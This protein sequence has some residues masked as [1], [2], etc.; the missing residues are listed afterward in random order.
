MTA[1]PQRSSLIDELLKRS[2]LQ[3]V[4]LPTYGPPVIVPTPDVLPVPAEPETQQLEL[5]LGLETL[6]LPSQVRTDLEQTRLHQENRQLKQRYRQALDEITQLELNLS[7][8]AGTHEIETTPIS[9]TTSPEVSSE[10]IPILGWSDWHV[11][12]RIDARTVNGLN[13]YTPEIAEVRA[14]QLAVNSLRL[15]QKERLDRQVKRMVL[16]LGGDFISGYIHPE[17]EESN[18][19]SPTQEIQLA[20]RLICQGIDL[21]LAQGDLEE[22]I[23]PCSIGNHGRT[24]DK[25]RA[26]T[27]AYNSFEWL[28]YCNLSRHYRQEPRVKFQ[29]ADGYCNYLRIF[30]RVLRFAHGDGGFKYQ[31]GVGGIH[32]G[33]NKWIMRANEA[34]KADM[35]V[36]GHFHSLKFDHNF[37]VNGS[38]IGPSAYSLRMGF[39]PERP[40][41]MFRLLDAQYGFTTCAPVLTE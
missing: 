41:Q 21:F 9:V 1:T 5:D 13:E 34:I 3:P 32:V 2:R 23:V 7:A 26:S 40:Q 6:D 31:G 30:D 11:G 18:W 38:L 16:W 22:I 33:L 28:M 10:V 25:S 29:I 36:I 20:E 12:E 24:Q 35:T 27:G 19:L 37:M 17:L 4:E 8:M 39:A 15:I 14:T